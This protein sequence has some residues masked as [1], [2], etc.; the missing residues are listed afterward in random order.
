MIMLYSALNLAEVP[1]FLRNDLLAQAV[2]LVRN[3]VLACKVPGVTMLAHA[4]A[5]S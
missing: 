5:T 3:A 1:V 2:E 4:T